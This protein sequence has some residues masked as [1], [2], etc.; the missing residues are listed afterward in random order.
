MEA[1]IPT[2]EEMKYLQLIMSVCLDCAL[3]KGTKDRETFISNLALITNQLG[4]IG[5]TNGTD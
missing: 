3:G 5:V 1:W 2:N 4:E